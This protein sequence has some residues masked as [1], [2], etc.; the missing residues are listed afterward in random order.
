MTMT[1][2]FWAYTAVA[3]AW[4]YPAL[5]WTAGEQPTREEVV[6]ERI[7]LQA[8][9]HFDFDRATLKASG[10]Q[11]LDEL[12]DKVKQHK[13]AERIRVVAYTDRLGSD[14]YNMRLSEARA[15]SVKDYLVS[16]GLP[17]EK[18]EARGMGKANPVVGCE[19]VRG[20]A[21]LIECLAPN[22]R[23]EVEIIVLKETTK[24]VAA[25]PPPPP[26][27]PPKRFLGRLTASYLKPNSGTSNLNGLPPGSK[28]QVG[29]DSQPSFT[30][31]YMVTDNIG[32]EL[33]GAAPFHLDIN[34]SGSINALGTVAKTMALPPVLSLQW[35]FIPNGVA[36]P[37]VGI[38][39]NYT[40]IYDEHATGNLDAALG[41]PTHVKA[42]NSF[43]WAAQGGVDFMVDDNWF[44]NFD[45]R[46]VN[47]DS[48]VKLVTNGVTRSLDLAVDPWVFSAG[49]G[50]RF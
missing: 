18:V 45:V 2:R 3:A 41:G 8:D 28:L 31:T 46:Y 15:E 12:V 49:I 9:T 7:T 6:T 43:S 35:H 44:L 27:P 32:L 11:K 1:R 19:G 33:L 34:G 5:G 29:E 38:G 48:S 39:M 20:R 22:R 40:W 4:A 13:E 50:R 37:Y 30:L 14:A 36:R 16:H 47:V 17:T 23:A 21:R 24:V 42:D 10:K 26:P 25:P